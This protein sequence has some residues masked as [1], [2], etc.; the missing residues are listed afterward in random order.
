VHLLEA[1]HT[2]PVLKLTCLRKSKKK[3]LNSVEKGRRTIGVRP[4][5]L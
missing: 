5:N 4:Q 2:A 1:Y 3:Q